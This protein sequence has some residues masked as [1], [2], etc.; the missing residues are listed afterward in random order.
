MT[1][2]GP[3][4][5][6]F[7]KEKKYSQSDVAE[8][9]GCSY[10]QV[11]QYENAKSIPPLPRLLRLMEILSIPPNL[12]IPNGSSKDHAASEDFFE[13]KL[14]Q[15]LASAKPDK[16]SGKY[17]SKTFRDAVALGK[18]FAA[19]PEPRKKMLAEIAKLLQY[20]PLLPVLLLMR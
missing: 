20:L 9:L 15:R 1:T 10:Q 11:Q 13:K 16:K 5:R 17:T 2:L 19:L 6:R 7:R 12:I 14:Q 3:V 4:L 18:L 8:M